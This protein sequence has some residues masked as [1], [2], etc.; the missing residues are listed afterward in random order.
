MQI[1]FTPLELVKKLPKFAYFPYIL[2]KV[3]PVGLV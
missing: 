2:Y 3:L 1:E